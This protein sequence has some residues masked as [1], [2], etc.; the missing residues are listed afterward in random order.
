MQFGTGLHSFSFTCGTRGQGI[1]L[2]IPANLISVLRAWEN[3]NGFD[4]RL[5]RKFTKLGSR[6]FLVH[7]GSIF[8]HRFLRHE[9]RSIFP[10]VLE[11]NRIQ[12]NGSG[13]QKKLGEKVL[14]FSLL[15]CVVGG[16]QLT[17][18]FDGA[19]ALSTLT[20]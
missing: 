8:G 13:L 19:V 12:R 1:F 9:V 2:F 18:C 20:T 5:N 14:D 16:F 4:N 11:L 7:H 10:V 6:L 17:T 15:G 3:L